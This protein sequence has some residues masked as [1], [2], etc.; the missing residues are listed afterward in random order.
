MPI[1]KVTTWKSTNSEMKAAL[2][3][4]LTRVTHEVTGAPLDKITVLIQEV[5]QADWAEAG[6]RGDDPDFRVQSRRQRY[7]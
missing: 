3:T 2:L 4:G 5:P 6:I 7:G 1:I